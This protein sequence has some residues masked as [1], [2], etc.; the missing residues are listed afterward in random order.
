[1]E[2]AASVWDPYLECLNHDIEMIQ[3][4]AVRFISNIKG[5]KSVTEAREKL[6]LDTLVN[7]Q[8]KIRH[9]LILRLLSNEEHHRLLVNDYDELCSDSPDN[10]PTTRAMARGV[11]LTI[12][13]KTSAYYNSFLPKTKI[14]IENCRGSH[15]EE[16]TSNCVT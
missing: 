9:N 1:M 13:A 14:N 10:T 8:M 6:C 5:R 16:T 2:Y 15:R 4:K 12:Y 7:R 3:N 11:P